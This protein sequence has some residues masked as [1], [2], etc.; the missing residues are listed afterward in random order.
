MRFICDTC[1]WFTCF[2]FYFCLKISWTNM[3]CI[4]TYEHAFVC[5]EC[6]Q[7]FFPQIDWN[8]W[9]HPFL[10]DEM[11]DI[12]NLMFILFKQLLALCRILILGS[13]EYGNPSKGLSLKLLRRRFWERLTLGWVWFSTFSYDDYKITLWKDLHSFKCNQ[14]S[15]IAIAVQ[16]YVESHIPCLSLMLIKI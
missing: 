6:G 4:C 2:L 16:W 14:G 5:V 1:F 10:R 3:L 8:E 15:M 9:M 11:L 7:F 13:Q 12:K